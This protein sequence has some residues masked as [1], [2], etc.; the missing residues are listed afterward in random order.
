MPVT[1]KSPNPEW[2][3][4]AISIDSQSDH[5]YVLRSS[6]ECVLQ[7][8]LFFFDFQG[9]VHVAILFHSYVLKSS[10]ECILRFSTL[11]FCRARY[12]WQFLSFSCSCVVFF[13]LCVRDWVLQ[14]GFSNA[15]SFI[16]CYFILIC[17]T[18]G[19][20]GVQVAM[21]KKLPNLLFFVF[22][23]MSSLMMCFFF[24]YVGAEWRWGRVGCKWQYHSPCRFFE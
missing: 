11:F 10:P 5:P 19:Q 1:L 7:W 18:A 15:A 13:H 4:S 9:G 8:S 2:N 3:K 12:K 16:L 14:N 17:L 23:R 20:G 6:L 22:F 24:G 21:Q